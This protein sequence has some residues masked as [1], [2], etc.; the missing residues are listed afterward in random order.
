MDFNIVILSDDEA[1]EFVEHRAH[2]RLTKNALDFLIK[3]WDQFSKSPEYSFNQK[4]IDIREE[5]DEEEFYD[6]LD[7][8]R[9]EEEM[10]YLDGEE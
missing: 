4:L 2:T 10:R 1:D 6:K 3:N 7:A 9:F 8:V 5:E